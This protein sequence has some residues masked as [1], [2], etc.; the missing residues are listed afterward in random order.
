MAN[1]RK[2]ET[3]LAFP[4][5]VRDQETKLQFFA[6]IDELSA[7]TQLPC[8]DSS[9]LPIPSELVDIR[10]NSE[11]IDEAQLV[12]KKSFKKEELVVEVPRS[13]ILSTETVIFDT[14]LDDF[15]NRDPITMH[16]PNVVLTLHLLNEL[17]KGKESKWYPYIQILPR[18]ILPVLE[19]KKED[20]ENVICSA[21]FSLMLKL[22]RSI[23]R[24][25]CYFFERLCQTNLPLVKYFTYEFYAWGVS[26]VSTRQNEIQSTLKGGR[27]VNALIP[28]LDMCNHNM[29]DFPAVSTHQSSQIIASNDLN[30]GDEVTIN[31]G[32]RTS[33]DFFIYNGF[34]PSEIDGDFINMT[35]SLDQN[36]SYY[37][38]RKALVEALGMSSYQSFKLEW[39]DKNSGMDDD[40]LMFL[41][42]FSLKDEDIEFVKQ[43]SGGPIPLLRLIHRLIKKEEELESKLDKD[44]VDMASRLE[45]TVDAYFRMRCSVLVSL[46][47]KAEVSKCPGEQYIRRLFDHERS[48]YRSYI[49]I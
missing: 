42:V 49:S 43:C 11:D 31:Y 24:Q 5:P 7:P 27:P 4:K 6:W 12:V 38:T 34:V 33:G 13:S 45:K 16:M 46:L 2:F 3:E 25:Y 32:K 35:L 37:L 20:F 21:N 18:K 44:I 40:L 39:K 8:P 36:K 15:V 19:F 14:S 28:I 47:D 9:R 1:L 22:V 41:I 30:P 17:S 29:S 23:A 48:I 10:F 26:I